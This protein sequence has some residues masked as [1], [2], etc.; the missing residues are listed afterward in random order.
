VTWEA[1]EFDYKA[2]EVLAVDHSED[3]GAVAE[4]AR[5]LAEALEG[6]RMRSAELQEMAKR[7]GI[8]SGTLKRA[9]AKLGVQAVHEGVGSASFWY[10]RLPKEIQDDHQVAQ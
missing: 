9:K 2:D 5:W 4:A 10:W 7:E 6:G 3:Q 8:S 1:G